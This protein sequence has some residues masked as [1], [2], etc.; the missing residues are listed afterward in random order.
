MKDLTLAVPVELLSPAAFQSFEGTYALDI[1]KAGP[2][3][4]EIKEP[5]TWQVDLTNTGDAVLVTG[6]VEGNLTT[7]CARCLESVTFPVVGEIEGYYLL[8]GEDEVPEDMEEDEFDVLPEDK[9]IDLA[10]LIQAALLVEVPLIP[11]CKDD[12]Q[13]LCPTCGVNLNTESCDCDPEAND[14]TENPFAVLKN[15]KFED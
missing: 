12:C 7:A 13:G 2:D 5:L 14:D 6:T 9:K 1:L 8:T 3:L 10:S 15:L 4:Y 11:L